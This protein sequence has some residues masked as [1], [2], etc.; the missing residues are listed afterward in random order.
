MASQQ[1]FEELFDPEFLA[2]LEHFSLQTRRII[3]SGRQ[4]DQLS[5]EQGSGLEFK[6]F[7]P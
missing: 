7:K 5:H 6:D 4:A 3:R 2:A 1:S